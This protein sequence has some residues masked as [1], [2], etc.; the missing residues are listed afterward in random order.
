[1]AGLAFLQTPLKEIVEEHS[2]D[3]TNTSFMIGGKKKKKKKKK[4]SNDDMSYSYMAED[5]MLDDGNKSHR[6]LNQE[7][8]K[9]EEEIKVAD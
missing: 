1:M 7:Q 4:R 2:G 5:D 8:R 9:N 6:S 3:L